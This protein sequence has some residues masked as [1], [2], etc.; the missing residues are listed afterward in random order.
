M[1]PS[2]LLYSWMIQ[3]CKA[4]DYLHNNSIIHRG[5]TP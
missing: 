1:L 4:L 2:Q 3:L 5:F